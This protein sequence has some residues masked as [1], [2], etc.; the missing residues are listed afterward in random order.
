LPYGTDLRIEEIRP[1]QGLKITCIERYNFSDKLKMEF[2]IFE[3][4]NPREMV[5]Y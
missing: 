2:S 4:E 3:S 5:V 1:S